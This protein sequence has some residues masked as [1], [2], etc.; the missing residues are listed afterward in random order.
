MR[1]RTKKIQR[2]VSSCKLFAL[3]T[4]LCL[5]SSLHA[6][7]LVLHVGTLLAVPGES[8]KDNQSIIVKDNRIIAVEDGFVD[9]PADAK[10]IDLKDKFVLP[11]LMD[12]HVH[13]LL[14]L[15]PQS[16]SQLLS[17]TPELSLLRGA[18]YARKTLHAGF[19]T[20]RD[21][22]GRP[23]S[24]YALRDAIEA[25]LI[26]GPRIYAAGSALA[27][28]GGH[29][30]ID[31]LRAD[32]MEL[33]TPTTICD[34]AIDCRRATRD[35]VKYGADWI[36]VTATGGVLSDTS[37]G[38]GVQMTDNELKEIM[39]TAHNLGRKVAAH[40]HGT[41]GVNAALRAG[42][43]SIDHGTFLNKQSIKLFK[44]TGAFLVPTLMPGH[45]VPLSMQGNPMYTNAIKQKA[46]L[47]SERS[48]QSFQMAQKAGVKIAF[49]TDTGVTPHGQNA[50]EFELMV[51]A[52]MSPADAIRAAT[53]TTSELLEISE[54]LGTIEQGK[55]A[56][57]I[58]VDGDPLN[59]IKVLVRVT[60]VI[61]D[62]RL[63]KHN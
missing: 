20:V 11:G 34:G 44:Q 12:M 48:R 63:V 22:G 28:T 45:F 47:A 57:I 1:Q 14:E 26:A 42:V 33:W 54:D 36:K 13:L 25:H 50:R 6:D 46:E 2:T 56:D 10:L 60:T 61:S 8:T 9:V 53:I 19:T 3:T 7:N 31:G 27:A 29:G 30:D 17:D 5:S 37:T 51:A 62:G 24:I 15:G 21:L 41:D 4:L 49:G 52:G 39:D 58:A 32:L 18:D 43:D 40:A 23:Q 38:L 55:L 16:R 35:A 59:D